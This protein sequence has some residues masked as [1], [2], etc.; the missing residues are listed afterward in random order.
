[1]QGFTRFCIEVI[2]NPFKAVTSSAFEVT[3]ST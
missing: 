1:M 3:Q 2:P